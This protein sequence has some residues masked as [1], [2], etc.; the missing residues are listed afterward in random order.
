MERVNIHGLIKKHCTKENGGMK[1]WRGD[2]NS[3]MRMGESTLVIL[4]TICFM[5]MVYL[6]GLTVQSMLA[7]SVTIRSMEKE[8][9]NGV[10]GKSLREDGIAG[11]D[12]VKEY[13]SYKMVIQKR[14]FGGRI[15]E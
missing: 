7:N 3:I 2:G 9:M 13:S 11:S 15:K 6:C 1:Q 5:G 14:E 4:R 8:S 10:M 12:K